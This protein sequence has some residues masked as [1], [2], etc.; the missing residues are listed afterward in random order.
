MNRRQ[1]LNRLDRAW[2][3]LKESYAGLTESQLLESGVVEEWSVKDILAHITTWEEETLTHLPLI[4]EGGRPPRYS[5]KYG[6]IDAF[7]AQIQS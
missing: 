2:V 6:G 5:T 4:L 3:A 7:N 1:L